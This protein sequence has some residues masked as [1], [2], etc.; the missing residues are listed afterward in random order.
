MFKLT[1]RSL[2]LSSAAGAAAVRLSAPNVASAQA[3]PRVRMAI[4]FGMAYLPAMVADKLGFFA[5]HAA[6]NGARGAVF[7]ISKV[8]S[9]T[10]INDALLSGSAEMGVYGS[11][12]L[13]IAWDKTRGPQQIKGVCGLSLTPYTLLANAARIASVKDFTDQD[14]IAVTSPIAPQAT[15][16]R[17]AAEKAFGPGKHDA[18][19][20]MMLSMPHPDALNALVNNVGVAGYFSTPPYT[21]S[22]L[23]DPKIHRIVTSA[24]ILGTKCTGA[25]L[26]AS[27]RFA[28][29]N[30]E[31]VKATVDAMRE[32]MDFIAAERRKAAEIYLELEP[33]RMTVDEAA[34]ILS[35]PERGYD[36][37][38]Q[39]L[40]AFAD[41]MQRTGQLRN[42]LARWQDAFFA[43]VHG[44]TGT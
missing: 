35:D 33:Q 10:A 25:T 11:T 21:A 44:L 32:G 3:V 15:L 23:K 34:E 5:K 12:A 30:L 28:D 29:A 39:G 1:R 37:A 41:F 42:K 43:P 20:N 2:L 18:L 27:A 24:Q 16:L 6:E 14:R 17:M 9:S 4:Q 31:L 26:G 38:P 36:L 13:L 7:D 8:G 40:M 22:A 19:D